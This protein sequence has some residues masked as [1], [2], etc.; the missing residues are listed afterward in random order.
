V[1]RSAHRY[2]LTLGEAKPFVT[3]RG[4]TMKKLLLLLVVVGLAVVAARKLQEA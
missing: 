4:G 2:V 3:G 1:A